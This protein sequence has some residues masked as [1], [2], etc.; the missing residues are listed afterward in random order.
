M[1]LALL[2]FL[3]HLNIESN[4]QAHSFKIKDSL[5]TIKFKCI[6]SLSFKI[7]NG[8]YRTFYDNYEEGFLYSIVYWDGSYISI[9]CGANAEIDLNKQKNAN[10]YSRTEHV[11]GLKIIY[12]NVTGER[13]YIF[14]EAFD[15]LSKK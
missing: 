7:P 1:K 6:D 9:L 13:L 14:N 12:E 4:V 2:M 11:K 5:V 10:L 8:K 3:W 15:L